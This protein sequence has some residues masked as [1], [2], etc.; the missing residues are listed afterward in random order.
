M[1][2]K[3]STVKLQEMVSRAV[4][5]AGNNKMI[6]LTSLMA[7]QLKKGR[8]T[9]ITT[10]GTNYL[11]IHEDNVEGDDFA[12]T[13]QVDTFS[14]LVARMTCENVV[15]ELKENCLAVG[16]NGKY[17]IE[18]PLDENGD[19]IKY[20]NPVENHKSTKTNAVNFSTINSILTTLKPA[21][22]TTMEYPCYTGYYVGSR[23]VATDT[24]KIAC[25]DVE[26]FEEPQLISPEM[27]NLLSV[28][29]AEKIYVDIDDDVIVFT[30]DNCVL[31]GH[32]MQGIEDFN[33]EGISGLVDTKFKSRCKIAKSGL[34]QLLDRLSLFV[35]TYDKNAIDL[36]FTKKGLQV[37]S[38]ASDGVELIPYMESDKFQEFTCSVDIEMLTTQVKAQVGDAIEV[39]YGLDNALKMK[40]GNVT[41]IV[42][43]L[44]EGDVE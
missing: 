3:I 38:K 33:F 2:L 26:V 37:S 8:L 10:D 34:L 23:V 27:M 21:L 9:I 40:D 44:E 29:T 20:P 32:T 1:K 43:F 22:A 12:I 18:L 4:K 30:T 16:G 41:L 42:A 39:Y 36:T 6:P 31:Y 15:L 24:Y 7:L 11:Y 19:P 17:S 5:G 35:G 14:K 28:M 25:M 13:I